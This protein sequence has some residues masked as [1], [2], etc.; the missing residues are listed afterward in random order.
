MTRILITGSSGFIG[1]NLLE[2]FSGRYEIHAP[3]STELD[4]MEEHGVRRYLET[5]NFD[6]IV[7]AATARSNR[8]LAAPLDLLDRN[9]RMFFNLARNE[10]LFDKL[11][12]FGSGAEFSRHAQPPRVS[13]DYFD[14]CVP[15][16]A[17]GFSKYICTKYAERNS[18]IVNLRLFGV[19][20]KYEAWD[21]RFISNACARVVCG[22]PIVIRQNVVFDY[23]YVSDLA[24]IVEWYIENTSRHTSYNVCTGR[25]WELRE[26]AE[27]VATVSGRNPELL[28]MS[29]GMGAEYTADNSRLLNEIPE[30]RFTP[31]QRGI[32]ELYQ[33]Y[34]ENKNAIDPSLLDYDGH[35]QESPIERYR[36]CNV[37]NAAR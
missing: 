12:Y 3:S 36:V 10:H 7:H 33:W 8:R 16:D 9:C 17:Y 6:V 29:S 22:L 14:A 4:L 1:K 30:I 21:V 32:E 25:S 34:Q 35:N 19:F 20:G 5:G 26:L 24:K 31:M 18:K 13:E 2:A 15:K 27:I 23:L 37:F 28:L 11:I